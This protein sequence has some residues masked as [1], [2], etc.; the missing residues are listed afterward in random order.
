MRRERGT[1]T[2][3]DRRATAPRRRP[4]PP[5]TSAPSAR[6][7]AHR[8]AT[9]LRLESPTSESVRRDGRPATPVVRRHRQRRV[10]WRNA[11]RRDWHW[12]NR[13]ADRGRRRCLDRDSPAPTPPTELRA[14]RHEA[15]TTRRR[16]P[17]SRLDTGR[18]VHLTAPSR[19]PHAG[20][21]PRRRPRRGRGRAARQE[22]HRTG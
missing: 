18:V 6:A 12:S 10:T 17:T 21:S 1:A 19:S 13:R 16:R 7:V 3:P 14:T 8:C 4:R 11:E 15:S 9:P 22:T 20:R 5:T 2:N